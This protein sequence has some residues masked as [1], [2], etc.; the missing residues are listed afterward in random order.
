MTPFLAPIAA[1]LEATLVGLR[2]VGFAA[3]AAELTLANSPAAYVIAGMEVVEDLSDSERIEELVT[4]TVGVVTVMR[5]Y[6]RGAESVDESALT[7]E[8]VLDALRGYKPAE[9]LSSLRH[10]GGKLTDYN[11]ESVR[12]T[13]EFTFRFCRGGS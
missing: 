2:E 12:W 11:A 9:A 8:S 1:H 3:D 13:D 6:R 7:R 4:A 10:R 5:H